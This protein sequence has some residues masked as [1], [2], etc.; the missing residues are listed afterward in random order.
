MALIV[1]FRSVLALEFPRQSSTLKALSLLVC[2]K[3]QVLA[4]ARAALPV[5]LSSST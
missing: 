5:Q 4:W 2:S 1:C 3:C